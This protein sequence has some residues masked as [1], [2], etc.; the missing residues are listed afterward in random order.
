VPA[1]LPKLETEI[2][3][4][5]DELGG[6]VDDLREIARGIHPAILPEGGLAPALRT[7]TR[8]AAVAVEL[9]LAGIT[10]LPE[11][12]EVTAYYVVSEALTN[13]TKHA[14]ASVVCVAVEERDDGLHLSVRDD[15]AG[16][17]IR[18]VARV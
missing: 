6:V 2:G 12:V 10:R 9:E 4:V 18:P 15:G 3:R 17:P 16:A 8:R 11:P 13:A 14:Q 7:L 1:E 5:A